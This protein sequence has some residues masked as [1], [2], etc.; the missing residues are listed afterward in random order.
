MH[1]NGLD[2]DTTTPMHALVWAVLSAGGIDEVLVP[3]IGGFS[4]KDF[5]VEEAYYR[6]PLP[7][8]GQP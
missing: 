2:R 7:G 6:S 5:S 3:E 4:V 8:E 1:A